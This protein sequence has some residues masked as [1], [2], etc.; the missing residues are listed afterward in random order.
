MA[1]NKR[2]YQAAKELKMSSKELIALLQK[3][4]YKVKNHMEVASPSMLTKVYKSLEIEKK[5]QQ[6]KG[7]APEPVVEEKEGT[8]KAK[9]APRPKEKEDLK[10]KRHKEILESITQEKVE[11]TVKQTLAK[12][13]FGARG[14]R[15][16]KKQVRESDKD[17]SRILK[18]PES[19]TVREI[20]QQL[21]ESPNEII[22]KCLDLG[23]MVTVNQGLDF[24][25]MALI[26]GEYGYGVEK[27][28][29][30]FPGAE[31]EEKESELA[32]RPPVVTVMGHVDHGKTTLLDY[33]R[34]SNVVAGEKGGITQHIGAYN[35]ETDF[36]RITFIDTPGHEAFTAMRARGSQATDIVVIIIGA[37]DGIMPQTIEA[38]DHAK[39]AG[40]PIIIAINKTDLPSANASNVKHQLAENDLLV[41]EL[42]GEILCAEISALKGK[43]VDHLLELISL[44]SELLELTANPNKN[45]VGVTLEAK[46]D[47]GKGPIATILVREGSLRNGDPFVVGLEFGKVRQMFDAQGETIDVATPS[48]PVRIM[49]ISGIPE[50]GDTFFVTDTEQESREI[51]ETRRTLKRQE[52]T[53]N[54]PKK[55]MLEDLKTQFEMGETESLKLVLKADVKGSLGAVK[56]VLESIQSSKIKLEIIH[57]SVGAITEAD[58]LLASASNAVVIGFNVFPDNRAEKAMRRENIEVKSYEVIYELKQEI[59]SALEGMLEPKKQEEYIGAAEVRQVFKISGQGRIAGCYVTDG[60]VRRRTKFKIKRDEEYVAEGEISSLKHFKDD[61]SEVKQGFECGINMGSFSDIREGDIIEAYEEKEIKQ[62]LE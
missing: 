58:I 44:Q 30:F 36:G 26:A 49:G 51:S 7:K 38:I 18:V 11:A 24:E 42:G 14:K 6:K 48:T 41:E 22:K 35:I 29:E 52:I 55:I 59:I 1:E 31:L 45:A 23:Y 13:E 20:A 25:T 34:K 32:V 10:Q 37:D 39:A 9:P 17:R 5:E 33:I 4:G 28:D 50:V 43:G 60:V 12:M 62:K 56:D 8:K 16:K 21:G 27:L 47:K 15:Y 54:P 40:V 61:V 57:S 53:S 46:I 3:L 2:I 19:L